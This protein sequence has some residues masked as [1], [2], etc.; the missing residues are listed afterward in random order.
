MTINST[1]LVAGAPLGPTPEPVFHRNRIL[2]LPRSPKVIAGLVILGLF[3]LVAIIGRWAAPYDPNLTD[4]SWVQHILVDGTGPGTNFPAQYYPL[5]LAP[6]VA[7][8]LGTTVFAQDVL[9]QVLI[10]TQATLFVGLFAAAIST[11]LSILFG[12]SAGYLGGNADEGLSLVANVFLAIPGLPLLIVLA[13]YVPS[14]GSSVVLVAGIISVTTWAYTARTL[15]AQT[16]SLRNRDFVEAARVSGES[17]LRIILVEVLP[18]LIPI[19][20]ASFLFTSLSAIGAYVAIAFLGLAGSPTS[21]PPGLWNWGEM[22]R[23]GF[24]NNAVRGGWWWWWAPPGIC[25]ALLGTGLALLNFGI[26]EFIN[27]R[28][29]TAGPSGRAARKAGIS[30]RTTSGITPVVGPPHSWG[31][32]AAGGGGAGAPEPVL[33]IHGLSVDY[34]YGDEAV[35]AVVDCDLV[36]R[37]GRV[38]GLAGESGS[39]KTTLAL[40]AIRLLRPPAVIT[41]GQVLF[42]SNPFSGDGPKGT[43]DVLSAGP[44]QL[45]AIRWSEIAV[46]L[47]SSLNALNP[48]ITIGAQFEDM[49]RVHRPQLSRAARLEKAGALLEMVGMNPDRL[50]SYAHELSGGMRQRAMIAMALAL[51]PQVVILDEPTTALDVVT[52]REILEELIGLRDRLGFAALFITHDLSLLVEIADDIA[53]MYAGRV[54]ERAPASALFHAPRLPYTHGLLHCF[55]PI[56]GKR[57]P[58]EGIPGSPPD[59][60]D[61]PSG[62][63]FHPRCRWAMQQCSDELPVLAPLDGSGREVA[64][65]LHRGAA[66]VPAELAQPEPAMVASK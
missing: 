60:R 30:G 36:L 15:R 62:C 57:A 3:A 46:V 28:L 17:R 29:R 27:P 19:V 13:D 38:L 52:Q 6:S 8:W 55:P 1:A 63:A 33:E 35:H 12:V 39:G 42:H 37:R 65:W 24:A 14:A 25:V 48:V 16:L 26:D 10:S 23:E 58:M 9:S 44:N 54:M 4:Q 47:Q 66:H 34:G 45:R 40:A 61:L 2:R 18:N 43:V 56:H 11:V 22:L 41:A 5:P 32:A 59:L 53:V 50:R 51:D 64:C 20:A 31:G 7:H 49:L 21:S